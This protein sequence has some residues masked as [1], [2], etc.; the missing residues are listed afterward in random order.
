[1]L[2]KLLF[3]F[4]LIPSISFANVIVYTMPGCGDCMKLE[5]FLKRNKVSY[6]ECD[7]TSNKQCQDTFLNNGWEETPVTNID[8]LTVGGYRPDVLKN[9]LKAKGYMK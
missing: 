2:R 5:S 6:V 3:L 4:M 7:I 8:G 1:M 9:I